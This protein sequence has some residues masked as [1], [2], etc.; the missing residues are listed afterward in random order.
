MILISANLRYYFMMKTKENSLIPLTCW[1][2]I[3]LYNNYTENTQIMYDI[4]LMK[5]WQPCITISAGKSTIALSDFHWGG[6]GGI[7]YSQSP[8]A[9]KAVL[10]L[11][12]IDLKG[13]RISMHSQGNNIYEL[14]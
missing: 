6:E 8:P 2:I 9:T 3:Y 10:P 5:I 7:S 11:H 13:M 1:E 4:L 12:N 14:I